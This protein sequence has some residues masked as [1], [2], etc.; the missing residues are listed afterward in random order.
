MTD[1]LMIPV[2]PP[3]LSLDTTIVLVNEHVPVL[4]DSSVSERRHKDREERLSVVLWRRPVVTLHYFLLE[5]LIT[6]KEWTLK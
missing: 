2:A 5:T 6:L 3:P 1:L 4:P